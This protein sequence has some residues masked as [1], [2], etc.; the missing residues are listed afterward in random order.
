[1][2]SVS[3]LYSYK[4]FYNHNHRVILQ[5]EHIFSI[6]IFIA[7]KKSTILRVLHDAGGN[8]EMTWV[9]RLLRNEKKKRFKGT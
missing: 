3:V 8:T 9:H 5:W 1:M 2:A 4:V 6:S 7:N